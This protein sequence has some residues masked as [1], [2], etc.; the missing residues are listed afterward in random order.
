MARRRKAA[1]DEAA[2]GALEP[3]PWWRLA[4]TGELPPDG[5]CI[6]AVNGRAVVPLVQMETLS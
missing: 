3:I 6:V 1:G 4:P 5:L 2:A